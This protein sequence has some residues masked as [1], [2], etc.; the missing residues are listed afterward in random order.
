[1][2]AFN[3][4]EMSV[5]V[6]ALRP[7]LVHASV[8]VSVVVIPELLQHQTLTKGCLHALTLDKCPVWLYTQLYQFSN[9]SLSL[10]LSVSPFLSLHPGWSNDSQ[11][12]IE[13]LVRD[14]SSSSG[15]STDCLSSGPLERNCLE[16]FCEPKWLQRSAGER[17]RG[18]KW[19]RNRPKKVRASVCGLLQTGGEG[20]AADRW[21]YG[22]RKTGLVSP[23]AWLCCPLLVWML[24]QL[25]TTTEPEINNSHAPPDIHPWSEICMAERRRETRGWGVEGE[26][27]GDQKGPATWRQLSLLER[28]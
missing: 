6:R 27:G 26:E 20:E 11:E 24:K 13:L 12:C 18:T 19:E 21:R 9:R 8:H 14:Q 4:V 15:R 7:E 2:S 5:C 17:D 28:Q 23:V 22:D 16:V 10:S 3:S 1:M 25:T